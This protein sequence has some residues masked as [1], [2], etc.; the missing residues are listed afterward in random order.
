[1]KLIK[2]DT[3]DTLVLIPAFNESKNII[4]LI[5][6]L[7]KYFQNILVINDGSH[8]NTKYLLDSQKIEFINHCINLGQGAAI[9]SG[10]K[11]FEKNNKFNY[12]ITFDADG[13]HR[14]S[15]ALNMLKVA[16]ERKLNAVIG[17]RFKSRKCIS[18]LPFFKKITLLLAKYY[19]R[20]FY[21]I[22][23]SDAHN[24][25]RVLDKECVRNYLLPIKSCGMH[26]ATEISFKLT[27]SKLKFVEYPV[28]I[29]YQGKKSQNPLNAINIIVNN[30]FYH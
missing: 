12:V 6:N 13:Q 7:K 28:N 30:I 17:T 24:G 27:N 3:K 18:E 25:L 19:E 1:M 8:D 11:I 23:L 20:I 15:D 9:D 10:L 29:K 16:K 22:K 2:K 5:K 4:S 14:V 21:G 26:H